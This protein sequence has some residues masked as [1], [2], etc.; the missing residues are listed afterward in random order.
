MKRIGSVGILGLAVVL[1]VGLA[2]AQDDAL[3]RAAPKPRG[4]T[5]PA[6]KPATTDSTQSTPTPELPADLKGILSVEQP[7]GMTVTGAVSNDAQDLAR[8]FQIV[9]HF[10]Q[11]SE[12]QAMGLRHLLQQRH[13]TVAPLLQAIME[14][15]AQIRS[16]LETGGSAAEIGQLVVE[17]HQ[18]RQ[19]IQ[20]AQENFLAAFI[21]LLNPEQEQRWH[22][23]QLAERLQPIIPAFKILHLI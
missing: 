17:I 13:E 15:E 1:F 11:L 21:D 10:L 4:A 19:L 8:A 5:T 7:S 3:F 16:L 12:D 9:A 23:V 2:Q 14:K 6:V 20:Q 22:A 18:L